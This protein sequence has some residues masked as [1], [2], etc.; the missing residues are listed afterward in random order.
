MSRDP[1]L[2]VAGRGDDVLGGERGDKRVHVGRGDAYERAAALR[3]PRRRD[4]PAE[5]LDAV[6]QEPVQAAHVGL[7]LGDP[8][9]LHQLDSGDRRVGRRHRRRARLEAPRGRRRRV[10]VDVHLEDVAIGEPARRR[11]LDP[12]HELAAAVEEAEPG[13]AEQ[14]LEHASGQEVAVERAHVDRQRADRLVGVDEHRRARLVRDAA[15]ALDV[16][17]AAVP[18][19]DVRDR[20]QRRPLVDC[21]LE[22]LQR[23][24]PVRFRRHVHDP[25]AAP[26]LRVRDLADSRELEVADHDRVAPV[27]EAEAADEPA[28]TR[29]DRGRDRDL[30]LAGVHE[31]RDRRPHRLEAADPVLPGR[32]VLVPVVEVAGVG[33]AH[34]V[35]ERSLRAAVDVDLPL[36]DRKAVPN[37]ARQ[38]GDVNGQGRPSADPRAGAAPRPFRTTRHARSGARTHGLRSRARRSRS[39]PRPGS[40]RPTRAPAG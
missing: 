12:L 29:G 30:V 31:P 6:V 33:V 23:D 16:E 40:P 15:D 14:V 34:R 1:Q 2:V 17:P 37:P 28:H 11:G 8:D 22:A 39:A 38:R 32:A 20:H 24:R 25:H 3:L 18:E 19:A 9:L 35:R 5:L 27:A 36:E 10:V 4:A 21:R 7:G 13:R 26:L